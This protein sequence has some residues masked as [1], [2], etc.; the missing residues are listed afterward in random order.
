MR[1]RRLL[2]P[3]GAAS[4]AE[5]SA[6]FFIWIATSSAIALVVGFC[7]GY[8]RGGESADQDW[9]EHLANGRDRRL[10]SGS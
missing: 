3:R 4:V 1:N 10:R 5:M 8:K 6:S 9:I 2:D 7:V